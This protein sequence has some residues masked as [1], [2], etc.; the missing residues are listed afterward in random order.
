MLILYV[1]DLS[2]QNLKTLSKLT[3]TLLLVTFVGGGGGMILVMV[4]NF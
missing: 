4:S 2:S 3:Q 1:V